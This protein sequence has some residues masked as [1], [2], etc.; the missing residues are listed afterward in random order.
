MLHCGVHVPIL[1]LERARCYPC[2][3][4]RHVQ[5]ADWGNECSSAAMTD[6]VAYP[7]GATLAGF[8]TGHSALH[9]Y[10]LNPYT[11]AAAS[12]PKH[13]SVRVLGVNTAQT[14]PNGA[15]GGQ[16]V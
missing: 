14:A 6:W 9:M 12:T 7:W 4:R 5:H 3:S 11:M 2:R 1:P 15:K 8:Y 13:K 16:Q 10:Q